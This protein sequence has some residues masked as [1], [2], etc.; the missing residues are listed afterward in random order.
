[1]KHSAKPHWQ[2]KSL[3]TP[4]PLLPANRRTK[5]TL[6]TQQQAKL[7]L[8]E[9]QGSLLLQ[10]PEILQERV[11]AHQCL[12]GPG[13]FA[14]FREI[15]D[16][17]RCNRAVRCGDLPI[18]ARYRRRYNPRG[19]VGYGS[20]HSRS[21]HRRARPAGTFLIADADKCPSPLRPIPD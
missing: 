14:S 1:M 2:A 10:A 12:R 19:L 20:K 4:R 13:P 8:P 17:Q 9:P 3:V 11:H 16:G 15:L 21:L 7:Q 6:L 5:V 18:F